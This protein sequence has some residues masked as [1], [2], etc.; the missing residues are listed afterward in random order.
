WAVVGMTPGPVRVRIDE[1]GFKSFQQ[2]IDL[3]SSQPARL[4][5]TL[6][7]GGASEVVSIGGVANSEKEARR[8]E[9]QARKVQD[10]AINAPSQNVA[11]LQKRVAG[12]LPVQVDVPHA[13]KSYRFVRP[14][15]LDEET[16][17]SFQYRTRDKGG[18]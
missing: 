13:G 7:V 6:E 9:M 12:I 8:L 5:V 10:Q 17:I 16:K 2:E 18:R 14:L 11:N 4:G 15:V 1:T 3:K